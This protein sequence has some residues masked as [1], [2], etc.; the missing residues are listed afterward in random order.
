[1]R[2]DRPKL[3]SV[4]NKGINKRPCRFNP[5]AL[6]RAVGPLGPW[7]VQRSRPDF[8]QRFADAS[9]PPNAIFQYLYHLNVQNPAGESAFSAISRQ[10]RWPKR[11]LLE[12]LLALPERCNQTKRQGY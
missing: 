11:P 10:F 7:L 8:G 3:N 1:M 2:G 6:L 5:L 9:L 12:R 4:L